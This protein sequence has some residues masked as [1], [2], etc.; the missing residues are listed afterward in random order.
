MTTS[1]P[2]LESQTDCAMSM[3]EM[4]VIKVEHLE[5]EKSD[6]NV[7]NSGKQQKCHFL[8]FCQLKRRPG[9]TTNA[10]CR[11]R[12]LIFVF[13]FLLYCILSFTILSFAIMIGDNGMNCELPANFDQ[14]PSTMEEYFSQRRRR[15]DI[16][17][18]HHLRCWSKPSE[19]KDK[20]NVSMHLPINKLQMKGTHNSYKLKPLFNLWALGINLMIPD[21]Q[22]QHDPLRVQLNND[23]RHFELDVH[24]GDSGRILNYHL[25]ELDKETHCRCFLHCLQTIKAWSDQNVNHL[26]IFIAL[27]VKNGHWIEDYK[28][29]LNTPSKNELE[30]IEKYILSVWWTGNDVDDRIFMPDQLRGNFTSLNAA[31]RA[32]GWPS[33]NEMRNKIVFT[34]LENDEVRNSYV[35]GPHESLRN[36]IMFTLPKLKN[37]DNLYDKD[38]AMIKFDSALDDVSDIS[39]NVNAGFLIRTRANTVLEQSNAERFK[40]VVNGGAQLVSLDGDVNMIWN[41]NILAK[42]KPIKHIGGSVKCGHAHMSFG[43]CD[44][45]KCS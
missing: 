1:E 22:Y 20:C 7:R 29:Y 24:F 2:T 28:A 31:V 5:T 19:Y 37:E 36:R 16:I 15:K 44:W 12:S 11:R 4:A 39:K 32:C 38:L 33:V 34:L 21:F 14:I 26:P 9:E 30:L 13:F 17:T 3:A 41:K 6:N 40:A 10:L 23:V 42:D 8:Y 35:E 18:E 25:P 43:G 27:E 45:D